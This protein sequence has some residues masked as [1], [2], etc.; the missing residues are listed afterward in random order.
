MSAV[1]APVVEPL[2]ML[3]DVLATSLEQMDCVCEELKLAQSVPELLCGCQASED[4]VSL[5]CITAY[6]VK[7][8]LFCEIMAA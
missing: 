2:K 1:V 7:P 4:P 6:Q 5:H 3:H 8:F